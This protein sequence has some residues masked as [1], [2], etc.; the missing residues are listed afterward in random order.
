MPELATSV[1]A[2]FRGERDIAVGNVV[3]SNIFNILS[4]LGF[5]SLVSP[6]GIQVSHAALIFDIPVMIGVALLCLPIFFTGYIISRTNGM[7]LIFFYLAYTAYLILGV[8]GHPGAPMLASIMLWCVIPVA[9][10][11][12]LVL[13]GRYWWGL[14]P[15]T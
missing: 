8:T 11:V 4:V 3:G 6:A 10:L 14:R 12:L 15:K 13:M 2:S 5:S 1:V 7:L 9:V